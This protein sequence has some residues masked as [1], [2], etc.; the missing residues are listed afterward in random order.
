MQTFWHDLRYGLQMLWKN[1]GFTA[2]AV[3]TLAL[4]IGANTALFSV[5]DTVLLKK[6][7]V[8]DPDRLVLFNSV[9]NKQFTPGSHN[10]SNRTDPATGLTTRSSFPY[11]TFVR[12]REQRGACSDIIA[13]SAIA[14]NVNADGLA[15]FA[16]AQAVTGNYYEVL[17]VPAFMGRMITYSDDNSA[18]SPVAVI[19][20]RYWQKRFGGRA[21]IVGKQ[22]NLNNIA[23]TVAGVAPP[24][25]EGA[26]DLGSSMDVTI[27]MGWE[28]QV[29]GDRSEFMGAGDWWLRIMGRLKPG[30]TI[31]QARASLELAFQ[32]SALDHREARQVLR[33]AMGRQPI[34]QLEPKDYPHLGAISGSR[35][36]MDGRQFFTKP[37]RLLL[38]VVA[39]VLLISCANV[40]NLLLV[41]AS[42][43]QKEIAVRLAMGASRWRLIR[44]LL[45]ESVLLSTL[46]G[47]VGVVI[48]LWIKDSLISVGEWAGRENSMSPRL[49]LR[50]LAFT[51]GLSL[52]TGIVFGIVPA[53]RATRVDL[54]PALKDTGRGSSGT[55]RSL[56]SRSLVVV[57]VSLSL[58]LL[59]GAGLLVRT[60][61][62]LHRVEPG[63]NDENLLLFVIDPSLLGYKDDRLRNFYQQV[64]ARI[65]A[66]PGV[67]AVTFSRVPLLSRMSSN[68][69][70]DL[71]NAK[72]GP[73]GRVPQ[74][75]EVYFH[76]VRENFTEA[77]GIPL[78]L[79]RTFTSKD[80]LKAPKVAVV[81]Q[82][83]AERLFPGVNPIGQ[84]FSMDYARPDPIEI[85]GL[86]KDAKY[87][88]QRD[89]IP[90]T[91]YRSWLQT[92]GA[93]NVMT[94]EV[95]TTGDPKA[96]VGAIRQA[97][98]EIDPNLPLNNI[99]TQIE[100]A[101]ETLS[102]ERL[103][104]K[105]MSLF[106]LL[107]QQLASIG[108]YGVLAYSVS[109]RT[110]EIGIRMALGAN[111][112]RMLTM[113]L[114]QGMTLTLIGVALGL[115]GAYVL[116]KYLES[117][118]SM[119]FG[120]Q[121]RDPLT[122]VATA[123]LLTVVALIACF[124][125]ARR[126]TKVDPMVA[127]RYE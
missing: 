29:D 43:R 114:R 101:D 66:V 88:S 122:F 75:A 27:P 72:P 53:L 89:E 63:F 20:H 24:G 16:H 18:A 121:P 127:L 47:A 23:F 1:P 126:A 97:V 100:Q 68:G 84:R 10:G 33:R 78:L 79:G 123:V 7:P 13:F 14:L 52:L 117:L 42:S 111:R 50:V 56:L 32:Q 49:D 28:T 26:M 38:G 64:S 95:R 5:V 61:I 57:Q 87:T 81:N 110:H 93:I 48:A 83:F 60:L 22:I 45:T 113:I 40:A 19:S 86:V 41:R 15:D 76:E 21:D 98:R 25:F 58:L 8:K 62:N 77:M 44:Q 104:A 35:G 17:G 105:L 91:M 82:T 108:L 96:F 73:D 34:S 124:I 2:I 118:N 80:D 106:G 102:L 9:S 46:G 99:K 112:G 30:A 54:T 4:G 94:F 67:R 51:F 116:T 12:M 120:V 74:T 6:L 65:E 69:T 90:A 3:L 70:F 85:I 55:T 107:A 103:F 115:A 71:P 119:L 39:V 109:R 125:P 31:E 37:L 36:E 59:I 11:Q 92:P